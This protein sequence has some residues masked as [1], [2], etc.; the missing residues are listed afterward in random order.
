MARSRR[1][2]GG[3][4]VH[5]YKRMLS[6][7][8][9]AWNTATVATT[10]AAI[11]GNAVNAPWLGVFRLDGISG[12]VSSSDFTNLYDQYR[13]NKLVLK[14]YLKVDPSAQAAGSASIPRLYMYRDRDDDNIPG[15]LDEMRENSTVRVKPMTLYRPV[16]VTC[17]PNCLNTVYSSAVASNYQPKFKQWL[18][19]ARPGTQHYAYKFAID[20]LTNINYRV[21]VEGTVY[22]SCRQPR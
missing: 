16:V 12:L 22:F 13:I 9:A 11:N 19:I 21:E 7:N 14:F 15:S 10:S 1:F 2:G 5:H 17:V 3:S 18:D 4:L 8:F 6:G 20:N